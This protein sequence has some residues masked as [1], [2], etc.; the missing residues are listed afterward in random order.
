MAKGAIGFDEGNRD[1]GYFDWTCSASMDKYQAE[2]G[3]NVSTTVHL[4][5]LA[6]HIDID[7]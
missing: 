3:R 7:I 4:P 1:E 2:L 6:L 5:S